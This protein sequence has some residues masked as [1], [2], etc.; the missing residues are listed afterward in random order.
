M[1]GKV[2]PSEPRNRKACGRE[3]ARVRAEREGG[4]G[5]NLLVGGGREG[6]RCRRRRGAVGQSAGLGLLLECP[7][8]PASEVTPRR[9]R[10][11]QAVAGQAVGLPERGTRPES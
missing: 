2:S 4:R 8:D 9:P 3:G 1:L 5:C 7:R 10:D 11:K 6:Q